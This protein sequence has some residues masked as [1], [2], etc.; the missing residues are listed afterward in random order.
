VT[1]VLF[2]TGSRSEYDLLE[3]I[4][5]LF[6]TSKKY[7]CHLAITGSH[8]SSKYGNSLDLIKRIKKINHYK[9]NIQVDRSF[10]R[11]IAKSISIAIKKFDLIYKKIL[12]SIIIV[13][14]DRFETFAAVT[15]AK[16]NLIPVAH[17]HGGE[18]TLGV[19]DNYWRHCISIMS[20]LHF[21]SNILYKKRLDQITNQPKY[22]YVVGALGLDNIK[23]IKFK[24]RKTLEKECKFIFNQNNLLI[25]CHSLSK[26]PIRNKKNFYNIIRAA[27]AISN[28]NI[29]ISYPGHDL[30]SDEIIDGIKKIKKLN[31]RNIFIFKNLGMINYLSL[32]KICDIIIGN[33]SSGIF[34]APYLGT[35]TLNVGSRQ[36]GRLKDKTVYNCQPDQLTIIKIIN[37]LLNI[38]K[39]KKKPKCDNIYGNGKASFKAFKIINNIDINKL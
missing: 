17:F 23:R 18:T 10:S 34:E 2:I 25:V 14:G 16:L 24:N 35:L 29:F 36:Q 22:S 38:I 19:Y 33:S 3:N 28:T 5:N 6:S 26:S 37:S 30:G 27:M 13:V 32:L 4:I 9:I 31:K 15:A 8:L 20:N 21:V 1:K 12:P 11:S 7:S 39:S